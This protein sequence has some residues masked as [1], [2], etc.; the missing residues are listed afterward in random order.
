MNTFLA[1]NICLAYIQNAH[2]A[3]NFQF[4]HNNQSHLMK[5]DD[6][7]S[8]FEAGSTAA[9]IIDLYFGSEK[10]KIPIILDTG[11]FTPFLQ[12]TDVSKNKGF[13][14]KSSSSYED[15]HQD[16]SVDYADSTS[17]KGT[18][19]EDDVSNTENGQKFKLN[20]GLVT[21][22]STQG[23]SSDTNVFGLGF[24]YDKPTL[25][26]DLKDNNVISRK[27]FSIY[28]SANDHSLGQITFGAIDTEKYTGDLVAVPLRSSGNGYVWW[29]YLT[30]LSAGCKS[31][32]G[33]NT[34]FISFD[35]GYTTGVTLP[36]AVHEKLM[37]NFDA[38]YESDSQNYVFDC[39]NATPLEVEV[40]G[41]KIEVPTSGFTKKVKNSDKCV[42]QNINVGSDD[43][44]ITFGWVFFPY[45]YG[46]FDAENKELLFGKPV[47]DTSDSH[48]EDLHDSIP[49]STQAS[50]YS[51]VSD[52]VTTN[53]ISRTSV[54][55]SST[56]IELEGTGVSSQG[57]CGN[58]RLARRFSLAA[59]N[60]PTLA[61]HVYEAV[62]ETA[63]A[64]SN[65]TANSSTAVPVSQYEDSA[66]TFGQTS[67]ILMLFSGI[68]ALLF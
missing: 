21:N 34:Y 33:G 53:S 2:A 26:D 15:K 45:I 60:T 4:N 44:T 43:N 39:D 65:V 63:S 51:S 20:F 7:N 31:A 8:D 1:I 49:G 12:S 22:A 57:S 62:S 28:S 66:S 23:V 52:A 68:V 41:H 42:L 29:T 5:R 24:D 40:M 13:D 9:P 16:F 32:T 17:Y 61:T 27:T 47:T 30:D 10:Q 19:S 14:Y 18:W 35:C 50:L 38:F 54:Q 67:F 48:I 46:V 58:K 56:S 25:I 36:S 59:D 6:F 55:T 64:G 3:L 11:S 37:N